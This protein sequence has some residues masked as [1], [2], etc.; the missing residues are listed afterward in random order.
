MAAPQTSG[1]EYRT[2]VGNFKFDTCQANED[3]Y[4]FEMPDSVE[5]NTATTF[6]ITKRHSY[7]TIDYGYNGTADLPSTDP[8]LQGL[9]DNGTVTASTVAKVPATFPTTLPTALTAT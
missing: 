3:N 6:N 4:G 8:R 5:V 2:D 1:L 7:G 9:P